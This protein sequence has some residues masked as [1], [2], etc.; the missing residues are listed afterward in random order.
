MEGIS[1]H[2]SSA[3]RFPEAKKDACRLLFFGLKSGGPEDEAYGK[4]PSDSPE[5]DPKRMGSPIAPRFFGSSRLGS[6]KG[7]SGALENVE[8]CLNGVVQYPPVPAVLDGIE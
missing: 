2:P 6:G 8:L 1:G 7:V 3:T 4:K 5:K